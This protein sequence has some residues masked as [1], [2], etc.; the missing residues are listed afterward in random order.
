MGAGAREVAGIATAL[1]KLGVTL[2]VV[3]AG[4]RGARGMV[5]S[6]DWSAR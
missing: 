4:A 5:T 1:A 3:D 6:G 2:A